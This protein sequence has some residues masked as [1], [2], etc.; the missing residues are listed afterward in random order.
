[1]IISDEETYTGLS[2]PQSIVQTMGI[3]IF[4]ILPIPCR[5]IRICLSKHIYVGKWHSRVTP[6]NFNQRKSVISTVKSRG[7]A[8]LVRNK[9]NNTYRSFVFTA[10]ESSDKFLSFT[11]RSGMF[12]GWTPSSTD[13][14]VRRSR[15]HTPD[16]NTM[17]IR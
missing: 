7:H 16:N 4:F 15:W 17:K 10:T 2:I 8:I 13:G 11:R 9:R 12:T 5:Y 14:W 1:M 6:N 3:K